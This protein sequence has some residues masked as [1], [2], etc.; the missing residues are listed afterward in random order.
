[1]CPCA[2]EEPA[3]ARNET[4]WYKN[5]RNRTGDGR[6]FSRRGI[7][8]REREASYVVQ[9]YT[10]QENSDRIDGKSAG[11][12]STTRT[13]YN[14]RST[15]SPHRAVLVSR[16]IDEFPPLHAT[17]KT[18]SQ[19]SRVR[20][21]YPISDWSRPRPPLPSP[22]HAHT[23]HPIRSFAVVSPRRIVL[24]GN[25]SKPT[26]GRRRRRRRFPREVNR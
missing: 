25:A 7:R 4:T 10:R 1:M 12:E 22:T 16:E 23:T 2:E 24:F 17:T 13:R 19:I 20:L 26:A 3:R 15:L 9:R 5:N 8:T 6:L 18:L 21:L 11:A 14:I